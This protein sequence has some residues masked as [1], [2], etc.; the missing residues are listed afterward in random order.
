LFFTPWSLIHIFVLRGAV[1]TFFTP[2]SRIHIFL[3]RGTGFTFFYSVEP[4]SHFFTPWSRIHKIFEIRVQSGSTSPQPCNFQKFRKKNFWISCNQFTK[5]C[6][7]Q[8]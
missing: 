7:S 4:D 5:L 2:W 8:K 6:E 3:L 1:F